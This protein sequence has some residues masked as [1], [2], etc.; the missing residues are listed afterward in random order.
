[1]HPLSDNPKPDL[2][3]RGGCDFGNINCQHEHLQ[4]LTLVEQFILRRSRCYRHYIKCSTPG[5]CTKLK[6][7]VVLVPQDIPDALIEGLRARVDAACAGISIVFGG[8]H[9]LLMAAHMPPKA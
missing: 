8:S 1:V 9:A 3:V 2:S 7:H 6:G 4:P 5:S